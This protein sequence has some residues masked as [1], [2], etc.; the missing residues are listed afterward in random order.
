MSDMLKQT[1]YELFEFWFSNEKEWFES[2]PSFD[3]I[4]KTK[5]SEYIKKYNITNLD[6]NDLN[7]IKDDYRMS[8][9][10]ILIHDQLIRHI[11]RNE[12][13]IINEFLNNILNFAK[14]TYIRLKYDLQPH[15]FCF[16]LLPLRHTNIFEEILY[17]INETK[18]KI[19]INQNEQ[20]YKRFLKASLERYIELNDDKINIKLIDLLPYNNSIDDIKQICEIGLRT[21][22]PTLFEEFSELIITKKISESIIQTIDYVRVILKETNIKKGIVSLSGGVDSMVLSYILKF[23]GIDIIALHINYN[24]RPE[25]SDECEIIKKW[26][27]FLNIKLYIRKIN[28]INRKEM[29]DYQLRD[30]YESYTR[31][32]RYNSYVNCDES[33][34][35]LVFLGHNHDDRFENIFTNIVSES[36]YENFCGMTTDTSIRFKNG[37]IR[38]IRPMLNIVKKD[39]YSFANYLSI[40]HFKD[41]TPKWSQRGKIRDNI[42]PNIEQW[43]S[44][45]LYCSA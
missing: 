7:K 31:D 30:L 12:K 13:N 36:H 19:K 8:I 6:K 29:M 25:C 5:Y 26:C 38:F 10:L 22:S 3:E 17:V 28:E 4:I 9:A 35:S 2:N 23:L 32:V 37:F 33:Y 11:K 45:L 43:D 14:Q 18:Y 42:R 24:N 15:H 27:E 16:V 1:L 41:S 34:D 39:I 40:P 21:Y 20:I 44:T